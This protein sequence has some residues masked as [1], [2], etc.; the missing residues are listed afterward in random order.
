M[1]PFLY[2]TPRILSILL[3]VFI[4]LFSLDIF[5]EGYSGWDL[6]A[7]LVMHLLPTLVAVAFIVIAWK[8]EKIGGLLF[9][10]LGIV[11]I[12]IGGFELMAILLFTFP[13]II[14]GSMFLLHHYGQRRTV[15]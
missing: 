12:F 6:V 9:I 4:S 10:I 14:I 7:G 3:V 15:T 11:F 8:W 1:K 13:S 5:S 2:W